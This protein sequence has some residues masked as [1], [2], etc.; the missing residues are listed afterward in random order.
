MAADSVLRALT[1]DGSFRVIAARTTDT[2]LGAVAAQGLSGTMARTFA[3]LLT[4]AILVRESMS[5]DLRVQAILQSDDKRS[6]MVADTHPDGM[7]RGL[8]QLAEGAT[9]F[10]LG[11]GAVL[12]VA[13]TLNNGSIHQGVVQIPEG[14][15][16]SRA[17]MAYMQES[18][19]TVTMIAVGALEEGGRVVAAGGYMLQL[20]PEVGEG[21]LMVMTERLH[22]FE[23]M[24]PLLA[25]GAASPEEL[26]AE[27]L[28]GMPYTQ[29]GAGQVHFGCTCDATRLAASL[30][31]LPRAD[32]E[33]MLAD[34]KPL[35]IVCDFCRK[36]YTFHPEQL[37][38]MLAQN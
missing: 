14:R 31:T 34:K 13:R 4:G 17:L 32:I 5:P 3:E 18:E 7:T 16:V 22:D 30:A 38:G 8:V 25:R 19:Q 33:S 1:N 37:R 6:R 36:Q 20:L 35:E 29:V 26:L 9:Q 15:S 11:E 23:A 28:Y 12:Q 2:V 21:E 24:E 10:G 27:T